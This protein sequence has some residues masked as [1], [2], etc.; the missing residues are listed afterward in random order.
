MP[1]DKLWNVIFF[2]N[3]ETNTA[4]EAAQEI[5]KISVTN[6]SYCTLTIKETV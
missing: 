2:K 1:I 3:V 5:M 6:D 4:K